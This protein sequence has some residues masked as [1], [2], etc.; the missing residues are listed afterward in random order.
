[1]KT[2]INGTDILE[3]GFPEGKIIGIALKINSM[4]MVR[5]SPMNNHVNKKLLR[6]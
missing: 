6:Y 2:Q 4:V 5:K 1:M 3:L